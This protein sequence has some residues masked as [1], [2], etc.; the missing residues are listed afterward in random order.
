MQWSDVTR[1]PPP[2]TLRQFAALCLIVFG[3]LATWRVWNGHADLPAA[4]LGGAGVVVGLIGLAR[5]SAVRYLFTGWMIAAFPIGWA[6]SRLMLGV[7][8]YGLFTPIGVVFRLMRRDALH[9]RRHQATSHWAE[10]T[11]AADVRQ[12]FRQF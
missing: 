1:T 2:K 12:Y 9:R 6:V 5:P 4:V 10:K 3:G 11:P 7:L 8:F